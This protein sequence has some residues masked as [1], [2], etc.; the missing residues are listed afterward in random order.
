[1]ALPI[2]FVGGLGGGRKGG[3]KRHGQGVAGETR[4]AAGLGGSVHGVVTLYQLR[5]EGRPG[6]ETGSRELKRADA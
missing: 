5:G 1:M 6:R 3:D 4:K 2:G